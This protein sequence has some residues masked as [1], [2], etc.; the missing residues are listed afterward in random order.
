MEV[1]TSVK[2]LTSIVNS[3]VG[4]HKVISISLTYLVAQKPLIKWNCQTHMIRSYTEPTAGKFSNSLVDSLLIIQHV[5]WKQRKRCDCIQTDS[6]YRKRVSEHPELHCLLVQQ[7]F[8]K[9]ELIT[10]AYF[11]TLVFSVRNSI[12]KSCLLFLVRCELQRTIE[13]VAI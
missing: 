6:W 5:D 7:R 12:S 11:Q 8:L 3:V 9:I 13:S 4:Y 2:M 10:S 1:F